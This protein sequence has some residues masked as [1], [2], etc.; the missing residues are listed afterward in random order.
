M[1]T[2]KRKLTKEKEQLLSASLAYQKKRAKLLWLVA[3]MALVAAAAFVV[4]ICVL[5]V[6]LSAADICFTA[7]M[8]II[9]FAG[10]IFLIFWNTKKIREIAFQVNTKNNQINEWEQR[11][12]NM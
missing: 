5:K 3:V 1:S 9:A 12:Q 7:V 6:G 4:R 11:L 10:P 8:S 2:K